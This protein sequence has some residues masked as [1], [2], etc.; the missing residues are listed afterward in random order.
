MK[1]TENKRDAIIE[2]LAD[3]LLKHGLKE[4][5]LRKMAVSAGM[6][7]RMLLHYF[8]DK[9]DIIE[10]ALSLVERRLTALLDSAR[11]ESMPFHELVPFLAA[12]V[13]DPSV[14]PYTRLALEL[15]AAAAGG[16]EFFL[17]TA[18][19]IFADFYE[20]IATVL[21]VEQEDNRAQLASLTFAIIEGCVLLDAVNSGLIVTQAMQGVA[22]LSSYND[23]AE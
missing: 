22:L 10:A 2:I 4:A 3:H 1:K 5:S 21:K 20:W 17:N 13:N 23:K 18:Q 8:V 19:Q 6:S 15:A 12:M 7:D 14:R 9:D 11:T 16:D